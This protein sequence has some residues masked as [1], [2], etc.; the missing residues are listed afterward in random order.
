VVGKDG[1]VLLQRLVEVHDQV[2]RTRSR[3]AKRD[4][5]AELLAG[6]EAQELALV[7]TYL[8]GRLR[9]RRTGLGWQSWG[10]PPPPA[11]EPALTVPEVDATFEQISV[12]GGQGSRSTRTSLLAGLLRRATAPEQDYL[13]ALALGEVR[14]GALDSVLLDAI[15]AATGVPLTTVRRAAMFTPDSGDVALA[16]ATG[17]VDALQGIGLRP[18]RPVRPMLAS[19]APDVPAALGGLPAG[20]ACYVDRKLDGVRLQVHRVDDDVRVYTRS[21]ED[22]TDRLPGVV[23][24]ARLLPASRAVLDGEVMLVV[25]DRP[26]PFQETASVV[27]QQ[28]GADDPRLVVSYFDLL[29]LDGLDLLDRPLAER[30]LR[31]TELVPASQVVPRL[32]LPDA[33]A[34]GAEE[35][36]V[37]FFDE[38]IAAGHEGVV[39]KDAAATYAA[40]RRGG[41][42]VKIKP[43]HTL[44]LVVVGVE[45]GSGRRRGLL[46]N[47]H[48]AARGGD[49]EPVMLGKTFKGMTDEVLA[50]QTERF[51]ELETGR[52][53]HVVQVRPE[54]VV[55]I[56]FD[57][58]QR[59]SRYPGGVALRFARVLRY[60]DDKPPTEIDTLETVRDLL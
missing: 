53:G 46:S 27:G 39:V 20:S 29:H 8:S 12:A 58:V 40:G 34:P 11:Q 9:Q 30:L 32:H 10:D 14:Q 36:A 18:G 56:A 25:D 50:W 44:D 35:A 13:R 49:G 31:L 28:S 19:T 2:R 54:Q 6:T 26:R 21:L 42:W 24:A 1:L 3:N 41:A 51:L 7:A 47:I 4:A 22:I 5:V 60:R 55:E 16:A 38:T 17:G 59:S 45:W 23:A 37:E 52:E 33:A 48:L 43:R 57:G 15:A